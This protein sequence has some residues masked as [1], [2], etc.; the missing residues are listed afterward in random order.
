MTGKRS[1]VIPSFWLKSLLI[2]PGLKEPAIRQPIGSVLVKPKG[3]QNRAIPIGIMTSLRKCTCIL[4]TEISGGF[5]SMTRDEAR[6]I[7]EMDREDAI[8]TILTRAE[9]ARKYDQFCN[10]PGTTLPLPA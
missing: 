2:L 5:L 8:Q 4:F 1:T 3:V 7:F 10:K 9:K 6:A